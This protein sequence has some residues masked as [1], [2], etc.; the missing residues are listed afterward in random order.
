[1]KI[2]NKLFKQFYHPGYGSYNLKKYAFHIAPKIQ[3]VN[4]INPYGETKYKRFN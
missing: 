3:L 2:A 1:M 4:I